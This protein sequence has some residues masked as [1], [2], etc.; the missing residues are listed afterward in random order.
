LKP[1][2]FECAAIFQIPWGKQFRTLVLGSRRGVK[3]QQYALFPLPLLNKVWGTA[4]TDSFIE[5]FLDTVGQTDRRPRFRRAQGPAYGHG[6]NGLVPI[7]ELTATAEVPDNADST[8]SAGSAG[9][10]ASAAS[11][12]EESGYSEPEGAPLGRR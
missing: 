3:H 6:A 2:E 11:S 8:G 12:G 10:E 9:S 5:K 1:S 7:S 4:K